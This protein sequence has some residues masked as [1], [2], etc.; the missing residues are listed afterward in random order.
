MIDRVVQKYLN[1]GVYDNMP[2]GFKPPKDFDWAYT[3]NPKNGKYNLVYIGTELIKETWGNGKFTY[4]KIQNGVE[5]VMLDGELVAYNTT[6]PDANE[7]WIK[8]KK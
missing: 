1:E 7:L 4:K 8:R 6:T 5:A 3:Q 2:K